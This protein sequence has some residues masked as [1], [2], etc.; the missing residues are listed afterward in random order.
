MTARRPGG[1]RRYK[2]AQ[3]ERLASRLQVHAMLSQREA[4]QA[5]Q[6]PDTKVWW[7][8]A[9]AANEALQALKAARGA[10]GITEA[11]PA[12]DR[13]KRPNPAEDELDHLGVP[14]RR[15]TPE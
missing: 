11:R 4:E 9:R 15:M 12:V 2:I 10:P 7:V 3:A 5:G 1:E 6:H 13:P 14:K 8:V